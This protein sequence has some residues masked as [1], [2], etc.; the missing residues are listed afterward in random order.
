MNQLSVKQTTPSAIS[1]P[2]D[3]WLLTEF[4]RSKSSDP[5]T[6][7]KAMRILIERHS[8]MVLGVCRRALGDQTDSE[9]AAQAVFLILWKKADSLTSASIGGWLHRTSL[10]ICKNAIRSRRIRRT[11]EQRVA[12]MQ[13]QTINPDENDWPAIRKVLDAEL[14]HLPEKYRVPLILFH[15]EGQTQN[16]IAERMSVAGS[17]VSY[18]L[19]RAREL[20]A[21]RLTRR[22]ITVGAALLATELS[23]VAHAGSIP[24]GFASSTATAAHLFGTGHLSVAGGLNSSTS[25]IASEFLAS[26]FLTPF[27]FAIAGLVG[28]LA[29]CSLMVSLIWGTGEEI[30][31]VHHSASPPSTAASH[32]SSPNEVDPSEQASNSA[33]VEEETDSQ[34]GGIEGQILCDGCVAPQAVLVKRSPPLQDILDESLLVDPQTS[35]VANIFIYLRK[36]PSSISPQFK[37]APTTPV[38]VDNIQTVSHPHSLFV[39]TG[40]PITFLNGSTTAI[41]VHTHPIMNQMN[42][43]VINAMD[44]TG[45]SI[46]LKKSEPTP[47]QIV[48]DIHPTASCYALVLDHPYGTITNSEGQFRIPHLPA[49]EHHFRIWHERA[50]FI[51]RNYRVV[52]V[53]GKTV[54]VSPLKVPAKSLS[55][56]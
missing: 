11:H 49:G 36:P 18:W 3:R 54:T 42:N 22:G 4:L 33:P 35:G 56:R 1:E 40:Q 45:K 16:E 9:D 29:A 43:M 41:V 31:T 21:N 30:P 53:G 28:S 10:H 15:L 38:V 23:S 26:T 55:K 7:E 13:I 37:E 19:A 24:S 6:S 47:I 39:Q 46:T 2:T 44:R 12:E 52:V 17:T 27:K 8:P 51:E 14:D 5:P 32:N 20:L 25:S 34:F 48:D 50:G